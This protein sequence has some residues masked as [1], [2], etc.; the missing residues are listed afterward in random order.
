MK[1]LSSRKH[2]EIVLCHAID[3]DRMNSWI[4]TMANTM[5]AKNKYKTE[6]FL[7]MVCGKS[8]IKNDWYIVKFKKN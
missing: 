4:I 5:A 8:K 2:I 6:G 7:K 3:I 1:L